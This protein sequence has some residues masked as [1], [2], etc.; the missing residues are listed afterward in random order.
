MADQGESLRPGEMQFRTCGA[1]FTV[2]AVL[3]TAIISA[4]G[5]WAAKPTNPSPPAPVCNE[6]E[7]REEVARRLRYLEQRVTFLE[8]M[9]KNER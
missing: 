5:T 1:K 3:V 8:D 6:P 2:P 4:I 9:R 7:Q